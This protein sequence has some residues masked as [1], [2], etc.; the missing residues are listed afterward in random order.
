MVPLQEVS[1]VIQQKKKKTEGERERER[2]KM[3]E[4]RKNKKKIA[5]IPQGFA[6][7]PDG[8]IVR[9]PTDSPVGTRAS[10]MTNLRCSLE[11]RRRA[12]QPGGLVGASQRRVASR[13]QPDPCLCA[14]RKAQICRKANGNRPSVRSRLRGRRAT[15][16]QMAVAAGSQSVIQ[17]RCSV[18]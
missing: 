2:E 12:A 7:I 18:A 6:V 14:V 16:G 4:G 1:E 9:L 5:R 13:L 17:S 8:E 10:M 15:P 3:E 11:T